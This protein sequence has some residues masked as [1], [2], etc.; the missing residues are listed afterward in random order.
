MTLATGFI[1]MGVSAV[2]GSIALVG[3]VIWV[4]NH[5]SGNEHNNDVVKHV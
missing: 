3:L 4:R 1:L 2:I 5:S